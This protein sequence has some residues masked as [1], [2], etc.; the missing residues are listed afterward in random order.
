MKLLRLITLCSIVF[1]TL[2]TSSAQAASRTTI[3]FDVDWLFL[4][5]DSS[6]AENPLFNDSAW[7]KLNVPHDWSIEGPFDKDSLTRGSG[8]FLPSGVGWYRKHFTLPSGSQNRRVFIDFDGVMANSDVWING[9]HLGK[10]PYGYVSFRYELTDHLNLGGDNVLAVRADT[11]AQPASRWYAGAGIYRHT[12]LVI[13]EPVHFENWSTF[14]TTRHIEAYTA[15]ILVRT[16]VVNQSNTQRNVALEI[17]LV[18]ANGRAQKAP[19]TSSQNI[20]PGKS[21]DFQQEIVVKNPLIWDK[22]EPN[23]Y[24]ATIRVRADNST[25]DEE[26]TTFGIR[27]FHFDPDTGF[28]LNGRNFKLKGVCLHHDGSAFGAAVPLRVWER[29]LEILRSLGVNA[30]RTAH[31]PPSPEFLDLCDRMGFLV[32]DEM[33]DAWTVAKNPYDYHL[34]FKEWSL[35][36]TR[37]TVRR[38]RNHPSII[39]YS[40]GNEIHD[41]PKPEIAKPILSSLVKVFHENDD[42][43]PVTQGL[44]RPNVSKD[45]DNGLADLLDVVGQNYRENEIL[46]AHKQKPTRKIVGT[47]N[48]HERS[49]WLPLRDNPEYAG[50]FLWSGIDYLGE[51]PGWPIVAYNS[52][53]LDRT[54]T[55]RPLGYQRAS[56]WNEKPM[57][58]MARRVAPTPLLPTDPG[59]SPIPDRRPQVLFSDWTPNKLGVHEENVEVYSNCD[60]VELFL[61][62]VSL[63]TQTRPADDSPRIWKVQYARG[64]LTAIGKNHKA[65][66]GFRR[67][68][69]SAP[70]GTTMMLQK[71]AT[72]EL[73]TA[74]PPAKI[75]LTPDRNALGSTWDEVVFVTATVVDANGVLIPTASDLIT[76]NVSGPG[77][78]AAVDSGNNASHEPFQASE[79]KAYQGRC[80]AM[81]KASS[82]KGRIT[83]TASAPGLKG[84][85]ASV[86]VRN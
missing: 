81:I 28:W 55:V 69:G 9:F 18:D 26:I 64:T 35:I 7:R 62:G 78:I 50:Q 80:F 5:G 37:D 60:E 52:G 68:D 19:T 63:G 47:E 15:K 85:S 16:T 43:R 45:Y 70:T 49:A 23:L 54:G 76:F 39:L 4:K 46:A 20:A 12:R 14:I 33:F 53:L 59:Y 30:I 40:A 32:M 34:Y 41:T 31:N 79:R 56:W 6:G 21:V 27:E 38:D 22:I 17:T 86:V 67:S 71:V 11:S 1:I 77:V 10:R 58:Y 72:Y 2:S 42:S 74:G 57:V 48:T 51:S 84:S 3:S 65:V 8:G 13:T 83:L 66:D 75:V 24:Q 29:R 44:F 36:D 25:L 82:A 61:N 73:R